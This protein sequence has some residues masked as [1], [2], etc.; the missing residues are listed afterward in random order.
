MPKRKRED[1]N[2]NISSIPCDIFKYRIS[3]FLN[4]KE[5]IYLSSTCR[6]IRKY[7]Y[8]LPYDN[9]VISNMGLPDELKVLF[10]HLGSIKKLTILNKSVLQL[11]DFIIPYLN[12][13][14]LIIDKQAYL[15]Y[16]DM[17][18]INVYYK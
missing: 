7:L 8:D 3:K 14:C 17:L 5:T 10:L 6:T 9:F 11:L 15:P 1:D 13:E 4:K 2:Y 18:K 16:I 12:L